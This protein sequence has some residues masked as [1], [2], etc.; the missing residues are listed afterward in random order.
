MAISTRNLENLPDI[1]RLREICQSI[2]VLDAILCPEWEKRLYSFDSKWDKNQ[3][4]A[5]MKDGEGSH[6]YI[7]FDDNGVIIKGLLRDCLMDPERKYEPE[8]YKGVLESAPIIFADFINDAAFDIDNTSFCVW[9]QYSDKEYKVGNI[10]FPDD[11]DPDGSE[12]L[13]YI[14]EDNPD[15]YREFAGEYYNKT[16]DIKILEKV[17]DQF[18]FDHKFIKSINPDI[19]LKDIIEDLA[20]IGYPLTVKFT[21]EIS[22]LKRDVLKDKS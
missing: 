18:P 9:R 13:L 6:Y 7:L 17:Y 20:V 14:L 11:E 16:I 1:E 2:A 5:S 19:D 15:I 3:M 8:I 4:M 10:E 21:E 22:L 12:Q